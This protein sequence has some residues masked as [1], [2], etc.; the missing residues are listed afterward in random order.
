MGVAVK[1]RQ[2][3]GRAAVTRQRVVARARL[4]AA[5]HGVVLIVEAPVGIE[6]AHQVGAARARRRAQRLGGDRR[7]GHVE[8]HYRERIALGSGGFD[9]ALHAQALPA[10]RRGRV[11]IGVES[12]PVERR[13]RHPLHVEP[14]LQLQVGQRVLAGERVRAQQIVGI[15]TRLASGDFQRHAVDAGDGGEGERQR[16]ALQHRR[17]RAHQ[18]DLEPAAR[19]HFGGERG[20]ERGEPAPRRSAHQRQWRRRS[21]PPRSARRRPTSAPA[22]CRRGASRSRARA[23]VPSSACRS[24][25]IASLRCSGD[26]GVNEGMRAQLHT[27]SHTAAQT[28]ANAGN[29]APDHFRSRKRSWKSGTSAINSTMSAAST[30]V[31]TASPRPSGP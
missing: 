31:T 26:S 3:I 5:A 4:V 17:A 11:G 18:I 12:E 28:A 14:H 8:A 30:S 22:A 7:A 24:A 2:K 29:A 20:A 1:L 10:V 19:P 21:P 27:A 9:E 13:R 25:D 16:P 23:G 15:E 6:V